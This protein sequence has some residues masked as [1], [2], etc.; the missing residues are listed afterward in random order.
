MAVGTGRHD[1]V[2]GSVDELGALLRPH[3]PVDLL[4]LEDLIFVLDGSFGFH[5][6][7]I[8]LLIRLQ[9]ELYLPL[10]G[11][12]LELLHEFIGHLLNIAEDVT[13]LPLVL[14]SGV[15]HNYS[16]F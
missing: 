6:F 9:I 5:Y 10:L 1:H 11:K 16:R 13:G 4:G 8:L 7:V 15:H 3:L 12:V 14:L 2:S